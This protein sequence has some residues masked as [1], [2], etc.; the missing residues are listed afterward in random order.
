MS[1]LWLSEPE[2]SSSL[3]AHFHWGVENPVAK[4]LSFADLLKAE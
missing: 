1:V 4:T 3:N 2:H